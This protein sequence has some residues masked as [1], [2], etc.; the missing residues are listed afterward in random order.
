MI[1]VKI[2]GGL[3]NQLFQW[4]YGYTLSK[5]HEVY[6]DTSFY[7]NTNIISPVSVRDYELPNI[8]NRHVPVVDNNVMNR[9]SSSKVQ[10]VLDRFDNNIPDFEQGKNYYLNGYWQSADLFKSNKEE[11][12]SSFNWP[13]LKQYDFKN[14][15][16]IHIRRGDY[17]NLSHVHPVQTL[18]YYQQALEYINPKGN[19]FVFSDDILWCKQNL[20]FKNQVFMEGNSNIEDLRYMSLCE[21]NIMANS[22]FSWWGVYLNNKEDKIVIC[23]K[24]W[25]SNGTDDTFIKMRDWIQM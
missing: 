19:V 7:N 5:E 24:Q 4:A 23:P 13:E 22:S 8:I 3:C 12:K 25:F 20:N 11:I 1:V 9:F 15:C 17:L 21:N 16:S 6:F 14:S 18:E 2:Q 10:V